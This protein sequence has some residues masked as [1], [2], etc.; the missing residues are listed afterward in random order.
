[1]RGRKIVAY[2]FLL[3]FAISLTVTMESAASDPGPPYIGI[4]KNKTRYDVSIPSGN[5][6]ATLVVPAHGWIEYIVWTPMFPLDAYYNGK[7]I[8]CDNVS[9]TP[10]KYQ[11]MCSKYD[12]MAEIVKPE[13]VGQPTGKYK[14]MKKRKRLKK[15][16]KV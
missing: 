3:M 10:G 7:P 16:V 9:V 11:Y 13:P 6:D 1:M 15:Q 2:V 5:S 12:F 14:P 8:W 4:I